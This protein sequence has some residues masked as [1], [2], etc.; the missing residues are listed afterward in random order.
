MNFNELSIDGTDL[1]RLT[2]EIFVREG[3]EV[4]WTGKGTDGG[5]DLIVVERTEGPL[6]SF[7][8]TWLVQCKHF[9]QSGKSVGKNEA[10]SIIMDCERVKA[11]GYLLVCTTALTSGLVTAYKELEESRVLKIRYWDEIRLEE[12]L[13][14]PCNFPLISQFFP[15]SSKNV[16]W[17]IQPTYYPSLWTAQYRNAFLYLSTRLSIHFKS[18]IY[19]TQAYDEIY[20]FQKKSKLN[21]KSVQLRAIYF[22]DKYTNYLVFLDIIFDK[23]NE[24]ENPFNTETIDLKKHIETTLSEEILP[25]ILTTD[26]GAVNVQWDVKIYYEKLF[27]D[28]FDPHAKEYYDPYIN[29]FK[30][31]YGR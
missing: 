28:G 21:M 22:D 12:R 13:M 11:D 27:S 30:Y 20:K 9:A 17:K 4:H 3:F 24:P 7:E 5:R 29:N 19:L 8:R 15:Q 10:N 31:G 14:K 1:E 6:S 18:F 25:Y 26:E 16:G 2:R 23:E